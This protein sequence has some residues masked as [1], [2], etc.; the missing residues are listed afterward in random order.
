MPSIRLQ[1]IMAAAGVASRRKA[2]EMMVAGRVTVNGQIVTELG[3][4]ADPERD[5]IRVDGKRLHAA[6]HFVYLLLNKPRGYVTT[7]S[8]PE[9]RPTVMHL[10]HGVS[11]R[12]YPV[13]RLDYLSEGLL[14]MTNDG[15]LAHKLTH[16]SSHVPRTYV[17]KVSGK[18]SAEALGKLR[19]GIEIGGVSAPG[20]LPAVKTAPVRVQLTRDT[21]NPW[22]EVTLF[23]GRNRQVRRMFEEVGHHVEKIRRVQ[24]GPLE[25]DV[26]PGSFRKLSPTEVELLRRAAAGKFTRPSRPF[27]RPVPARASR[28]LP[29]VAGKAARPAIGNR[30]RQEFGERG[31]PARARTLVPTRPVPT[32]AG[33][34]RGPA[35]RGGRTK[36]AKSRPAED[37]RGTRDRRPF[38]GEGGRGK[39]A[40][41]RPAEGGRGT[42]DR[43]PFAEDGGRAKFA[44]SRPAEG[45]RATPDRGARRTGSAR[46]GKKEVNR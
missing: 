43:R 20:S 22:Y 5:H 1:K 34:G 31:A 6:E 26:P 16:P 33:S 15:P 17:V 7:V 25:L 45:G 32:R 37:G 12:V 28:P 2:E 42:R 40:K 11:A 19:G 39:F 3:A 9:G 30:G 35:D 13:G 29:H 46:H 41:S 4:K 36:F 24:L 21:A 44:K 18:P 8:D 14:L 27:S 10:L 23:E 38:A